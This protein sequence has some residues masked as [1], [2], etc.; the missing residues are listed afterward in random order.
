[1]EISSI[2][3]LNILPH[4]GLIAGNRFNEIYT[5]LIAGPIRTEGEIRWFVQD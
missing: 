4:K 2:A 1:M 3:A 5:A